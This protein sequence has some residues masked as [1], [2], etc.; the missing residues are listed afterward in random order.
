MH[1]RRILAPNPG[2]FTGAG[3]NTYLVASG[4]ACLVIDPGPEDDRHLAAIVNAVAGSRPVGILV[5]HFHFD[6]L[7]LAEQLSAFL[8]VPVSVPGTIKGFRTLSDGEAIE[9]GEERLVSMHTPG[10]TA[11][12]TC[13][14]AEDQLFA[15]DL[16]KGDSTVVIEDLAAY[17]DSLA[18]VV[19]LPLRVI[20]P[21]HGDAITDPVAVVSATIAHRLARH[22]QI[23]ASV[24]SG[25]ST[26]EEIVEAIYPDLEPLLRPVAVQS[27]LA[28]LRQLAVDGRVRLSEAGA[29]SVES[30]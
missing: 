14:V 19:R 20:Y 6:H 17:L 11:E 18:R 3:T 26:L 2:P 28:H 5:T 9:V 25:A 21:G 24:E 13:F 8:A 4:G 10:H 22:Q 7:G 27:V 23:T 1:V 16:L 15:G 29:V 30:A 12:H